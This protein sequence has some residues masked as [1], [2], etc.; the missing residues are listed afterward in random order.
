MKIFLL[1]TALAASSA[2]AFSST[3][4]QEAPTMQRKAPSTSGVDIELA[5]VE[6]LFDRIQQV[7]P[8]ARSVIARG[9]SV[10]KHAGGFGDVDDSCKYRISFFE[11][12]S[13][14]RI[15]LTKLDRLLRQGL[16]I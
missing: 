8:L 2:D 11:F 3:L 6:E 14:L 13:I 5:D 1:V 4:F 7:S 9:N 12:L 10:T 16:K 15:V